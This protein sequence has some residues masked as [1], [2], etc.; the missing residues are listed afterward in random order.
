MKRIIRL[1]EN[2]LAR[3][4]KRVIIEQESL[5]KEGYDPTTK[6]YTV[7]SDNKITSSD[8][9]FLRWPMVVGPG[10]KIYRYSLQDPDVGKIT[11]PG[12]DYPIIIKVAGSG[13]FMFAS[14]TSNTFK[15]NQ[16]GPVINDLRNG[17][18][19]RVINQYFCGQGR[20]DQNKGIPTKT[21]PVVGPYPIKSPGTKDV[22]CKNKTPYQVFVDAKLDWYAERKKWVDSGCNGTKPCVMG[23]ANTNINLRNAFCDGTWNKPKP[24]PYVPDF[25]GIAPIPSDKPTSP[26]TITP[27]QSKIVPR[28]K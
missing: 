27:D 20:I 11:Y 26:E 7:Q 6:V 12:S 1:T 13:K 19:T 14:C 24:G 28:G 8:D 17:D 25:E 2:D 22:G 16:S 15:Y 3:I 10:S 21:T 4:V 9:Y 23:D 5:L 18:L